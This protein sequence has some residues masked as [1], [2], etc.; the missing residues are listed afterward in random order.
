MVRLRVRVSPGA[1]A[2]Q[3]VGWQGDVLRV[4]V[5]AAPER[6]RAN[7]AVCALIANALRLPAGSVIVQRGH[8]SREKRLVIEGVSE[9]AM[10]ERLGAP[11]L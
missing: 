8:T 11:M 9:K 10:R 1:K 4:R 6:G 2:D 5:R 3:I 7:E